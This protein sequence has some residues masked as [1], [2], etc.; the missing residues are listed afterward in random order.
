MAFLKFKSTAKT[1]DI[2]RLSG[3]LIIRFPALALGSDD[4]GAGVGRFLS[5]QIQSPKKRIK[6]S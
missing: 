5:C 1:N 2:L 6:S 3:K 4:F